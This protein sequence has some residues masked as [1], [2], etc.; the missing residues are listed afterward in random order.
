MVVLPSSAPDAK[1]Q[2]ADD[3]VKLLA[4]TIN[5][6]RRGEIDPKVANAVG[7]LGG[8]LLK[9]MLA[10][11]TESRIA[12][13]EAIVKRHPAMSESHFEEDQERFVSG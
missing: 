4:E 9:A 6:V 5:Q 7:Y 8:L 3:A 11:E 2:N 1:L 12:T 13:L 10:T